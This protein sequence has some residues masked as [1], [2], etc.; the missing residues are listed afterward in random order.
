[1]TRRL[2]T[3]VA[4]LAVSALLVFGSSGTSADEGH[5]HGADEKPAQ[6]SQTEHVIEEAL[7]L[8]HEDGPHD[9]RDHGGAHSGRARAGF[10]SAV[11]SN[12]PKPLAWL[13]KFH[14]PLTHFPIALFVAAALAELLFI[15][16]GSSQFEHAARFCVWL[17]AG[18]ALA[19][20]SLGWLFGG[21][22]IVDKE[23]VMTAHR[24][25]GT[26]TALLAI[27]VLFLSERAVSG[28]APRSQ[29]R[30]ALFA[31]ATLVT[32]TGFLGGTLIYGLDHYAW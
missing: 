31:A 9:H 27:G 32:V 20:A 14:P 5:S 29:Y 11:E 10:S 17:G 18:G 3:G 8:A 28:R 6:G 23:W 1:M 22:H 30:L 16:T 7:T 2:T 21:F 4:I 12:V 24:W 25:A 19:A 15:R 26:G 13:G